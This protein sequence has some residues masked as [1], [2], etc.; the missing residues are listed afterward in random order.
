MRITLTKAILFTLIGV[1]FAQIIFYYPNLPEIVATHFDASGTPNGIMPKRL[2]L[3]FEIALLLLIVSESLLIPFIVEKVPL[4]FI[5]LPNRDYWFAN[6]RRA[7]T[8]EWL[9]GRFD[10]LGILL[11]TFFIVTNQIVLRANVQ[12]S[13]LP[14]WLFV[15]VLGVF[16]GALAAWMIGFVRKFRRIE[17]TS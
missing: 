13:A 15:A 12:R 1:F 14:V 2:F 16:V 8:L 9:R 7:T 17:S 4:R 10:A 6:G 3:T 11:V 5:S